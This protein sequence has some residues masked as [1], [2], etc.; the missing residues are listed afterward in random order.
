MAK[1]VRVTVNEEPGSTDLV[2]VEVTCVVRSE[3]EVGKSVD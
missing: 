2:K 1:C 3:T